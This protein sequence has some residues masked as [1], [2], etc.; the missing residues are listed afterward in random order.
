MSSPCH[1]ADVPLDL[2][3]GRGT[4]RKFLM[5]RLE[6]PGAMLKSTDMGCIESISPRS[7]GLLAMSTAQ[8]ISPLLI[9]ALC[10]ARERQRVAVLVT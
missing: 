2:E 1:T 6:H 3:Q 9:K 4:S 10:P 5:G 8:T 7:E